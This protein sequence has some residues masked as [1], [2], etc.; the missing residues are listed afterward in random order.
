LAAARVGRERE[1]REEETGEHRVGG[2][3][4]DWGIDILLS[5][6]EAEA[7]EAIENKDKLLCKRKRL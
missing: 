1:R 5:T 7:G 4:C 3:T 6:F 2:R